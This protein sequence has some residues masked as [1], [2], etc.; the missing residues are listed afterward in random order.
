MPESLYI[1]TLSDSGVSCKDP[2]GDLESVEWA[3]L[4]RVEI[5]TNDHGPFLPDVF[6]VLHGAKTGCVVPKWATGES[7]LSHR[8]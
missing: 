3:D 5:V 1:I 8:L 7:E 6:W 2:D 4:E